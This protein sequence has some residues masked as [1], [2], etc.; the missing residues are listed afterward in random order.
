MPPL[1]AIVLVLA[2]F[3]GWAWMR[4]HNP[5]LAREPELAAHLLVDVVSLSGLLYFS[6]GATN[7]FVSFY[8]PIL[9][10][11]SA[12]LPW[13]FALFLALASIAAYSLLG[14]FY[15]PLRLQDTDQAVN[16]HL[17]GMWANFAGSAGLICWF[18]A[19]MSGALRERDAQLALAR[20]QHLHS[21]RI[22]A[23]GAQAASTAH[24]M[25]TPLSTVAIIVGELRAE[26]SQ[27]SVLAEFRDDL[28]VIDAQVALCKVALDRMNLHAL[29]EATASAAPVVLSAWLMDFIAGWRLRYPATP[30]RQSIPDGPCRV[31]DSRIVA[32]ILLTLLDNAVHASKDGSVPLTVTLAVDAECAK[33][34]IEDSGHG[35]ATD[36]QCRLGYEPVRSNSGGQGIGLMLA[37]ANARQIGARIELAA[38][39]PRGTVATLTMPMV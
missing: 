16:Y 21:D 13:R 11:A 15:Q 5:A 24:E 27:R 14:F 12:V 26:A 6:G 20:E 4:L 2:L 25:G 38:R 9:A 8:L 30:L 35:I 37:F 32:Q 7:P 10:V 19:R 17:F 31:A 28:A 3:N 33:V 1:L 22:V 29:A 39:L 36:L 18:V 23:L 34:V